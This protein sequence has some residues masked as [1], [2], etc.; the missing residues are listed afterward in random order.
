MRS[1]PAL[2]LILLL[3]AP[4]LLSAGEVPVQL[5]PE[6]LKGVKKALVAEV[7]AGAIPGGLVLV[8]CGGEVVVCETAGFMD[9]EGKRPVRRDTIFRAYSMTKPITAVAALQ[10]Y[11]RG[12]LDLDDPVANYLP[13]LAKVT[14]AGAKPGAQ[15]RAMTVRDLMRHTSGLSYGWGGSAADQGYRKVNILDPEAPLEALTKKL[16]GLPLDHAPGSAWKYSISLDV[17]GRVVEVVAKKSLADYFQE[18]IFAPLGMQDTA[19][20]VPEDK[21]P[22]F[23]TNY[24]Y[25][26]GK[27]LTLLDAPTTSRYAKKAILHSGGGGLVTTVD[28]Y[29]AFAQAL[30]H[31]GSWGGVQILRP[32]TT[33]LMTSDQLPEGLSVRFAGRAIKQLGFG[34]GVSVW[35][36]NASP[37]GIKGEYGWG[38]AASTTFWVSPAD[39]IVVL[40]MSQ[41]M[42]RT[43]QLDLKIKPLVYGARRRGPL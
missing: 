27:G 23:A 30:L 12:L 2:T 1:F 6:R 24:S 32:E 25:S 34:F 16:G 31:G 22:R 5:S 21:L 41:V 7:E 33:A 9:R 19:F 40:T 11:E 35:R 8:A 10:L 17:L 13:E 42:P 28:D 15:A 38:G 29:L 4:A 26:L 37:F 39:R 3:S 20:E 14:V 36:E 43:R 18:R